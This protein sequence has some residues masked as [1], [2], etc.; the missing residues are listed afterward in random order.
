MVNVSVHK[1]DLKQKYPVQIVAYKHLLNTINTVE[2]TK[3]TKTRCEIGEKVNINETEIKIE[4]G[5][6]YS[7]EF[8]SIVL[9]EDSSS[10]FISCVNSDKRS[11]IETFTDLHF[12]TTIP[13]W[14]PNRELVAAA[15]AYFQLRCIINRRHR[16]TPCQ[17]LKQYY[18]RTVFKQ[19]TNLN[20]WVLKFA[21]NKNL[22]SKFKISIKRIKFNEKTYVTFILKSWT[23]HFTSKRLKSFSLILIFDSN[24]SRSTSI[25][26]GKR[27]FISKLFISLLKDELKSVLFAFP[28]NASIRKKCPPNLKIIIFP[29]PNRNLMNLTLKKIHLRT[30]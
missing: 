14:S 18:M 15:K 10:V 25:S 11:N 13:E 30:Y 9:G 19:I 17:I 23:N 16:V 8:E 22:S 3:E 26:I 29:I 4:K 7:N 28:I 21:E 20:V 1:S 6:I 24:S 2:L 27:S 5:Y 12:T